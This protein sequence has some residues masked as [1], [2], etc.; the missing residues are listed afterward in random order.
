MDI[1]GVD[2]L[3]GAGKANQFHRDAL[4]MPQHLPF[5]K[6][7]ERSFHLVRRKEQYTHLLFGR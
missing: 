1:D 7:G 6:D 2:L 3:A 4:F 5:R